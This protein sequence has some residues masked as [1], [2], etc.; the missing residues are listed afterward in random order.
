MDVRRCRRCKRK[1][2]DD[3]PEEVR[4]YKTC[5][6]CRIIERNKKNLRKPLA[7]ETMLYGLKQFREQQ[8]TEN[9]IEEEGL[10]KDEFLKG[11]IINHSIMMLK[12]LKC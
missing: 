8:S 5:A 1:R 3:E 12:L 2:L 11:I 10:L 7:E 9:Y 4:Q 6:K